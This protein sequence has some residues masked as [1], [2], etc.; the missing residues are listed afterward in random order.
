[1]ENIC[2]RLDH[3]EDKYQGLNR[4]LRNYYIQVAIK[5]RQS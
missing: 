1:M 3:E 4:R 5:K 2:N